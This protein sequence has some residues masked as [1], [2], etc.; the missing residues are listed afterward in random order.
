MVVSGLRRIG[1][2]VVV[3]GK[4]R[5]RQFGEVVGKRRERREIPSMSFKTEC[6]ICT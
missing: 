4:Q 6:V 1:E 5:E 2:V 3:V